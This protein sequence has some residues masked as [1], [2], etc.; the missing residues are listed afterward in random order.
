[1]KKL[2]LLLLFLSLMVNMYPQQLS[3]IRRAA[4]QGDVS[5]QSNLA[6]CYYHGQGINQDYM[7]A[8]YWYNMAAEQGDVR[9]QRNLGYCYLNGQ[10]VIRDY[11]QAVNW[12]RKA[13]EQGDVSS[14][15]TLGSFYY[16]GHG[17]AKDYIQAVYWYGVAAEHGNTMA[18]FGLA[19]CY[20]YGNGVTSNNNM[21][22]YWFERAKENRDGSLTVADINNIESNINNL[23]VHSVTEAV[24]NTTSSAIGQNAKNFTPKVEK[25]NNVKSTTSNISAI[26]NMDGYIIKVEGDKI[27]LKTLSRNIKISDV[28]SVMSKNELIID[29]VTRKEVR[30]E[31][32][33][34]GH[35]KITAVQSEYSI[36]IVYGDA[37]TVLAEGMN[38]RKESTLPVNNYSE[39][40][41]M[42]A[43]AEVNFPQAMNTMVGDTYSGGGYIG[44]YV[45]AAL[46]EQLLKS[47][48]IQLIDRSIL[49]TQR[50][51][52]SMASIG[53]IDYNTMLKYG[54]TMGA[55]YIVKITMQ[56]PDVATIGNN[57][58]VAGIMRTTRSIANSYSS[59]GNNS[60]GTSQPIQQAIPE[61]VS[62]RNVKVLVNIAAH[63]VDLQTGR[64]LF[65]SK[66]TGK[67]S[68]AP[69]LSFEITAVGRNTDIN[70]GADFFQTITGKA[71]EDAFKHIG[72]E[73]ITYFNRNL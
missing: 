69:Q 10:G 31:P 13:A 60:Y 53:E 54:K 59:N 16:Y 7:Q 63:V 30:L 17:I 20:Y 24:P 66:G 68:G 70:Q 37:N 12:Y 35:I 21:A 23:K 44:D 64:V 1:M 42:I 73:L 55:R 26:N 40:I 45:S 25:V 61:N 5:A 38:I 46:M 71:V 50:D 6:A 32:E 56:K 19:Y 57:I 41:V 9:S 72:R 48:K 3:D 27:Y 67:A 29:P 65:M 51:E 49:Q 4:E 28:V 34:V 2:L 22:L 36:G 47:N 43:P 8:V 39:A 52:L 15:N 58:P 14:Q 11:S 62:T 33:V 18:Q